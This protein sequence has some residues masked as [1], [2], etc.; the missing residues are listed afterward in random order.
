MTV[1]YPLAA[2]TDPGPQ[3]VALQFRARVAASESIFTGAVQ[4]YEHTGLVWSASVGLPQM[5]NIDQA[6]E[7]AGFLTALNGRE[8]T[9]SMAPPQYAAPRGT[10]AANIAVA[11]AAAIRAKSVDVKG[12]T[13]GATLLVGDLI[14]IASRLYRVVEDATADGS[15]E[16]TLTLSHGL[17]AAAAVD[18]VV[19]VLSPVGTWRL[20][21]P[22][23]V[24][25]IQPGGVSGMSFLAV[26][27]I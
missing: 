13:V 8:G 6:K 2:P 3:T 16:A 9:F 15:G 5:R 11:A 25:N 7:W 4:T 24:Q 10:Q 21:D 1:T 12:M 22:T 20:G 17:R 26:E 23:V 18:D 14:S 27:A 19:T